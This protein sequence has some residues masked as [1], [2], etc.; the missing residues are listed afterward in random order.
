MSLME[1][2]DFPFLKIPF[3]PVAQ[4]SL[5]LSLSL[6]QYMIIHEVLWGTGR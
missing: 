3:S 5:S 4:L 1:Q 6:I 2:T